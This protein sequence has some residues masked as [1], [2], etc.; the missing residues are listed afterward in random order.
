MV[1]RAIFRS[2]IEENTSRWNNI[3]DKMLHVFLTLKEI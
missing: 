1:L 3:T 2:K